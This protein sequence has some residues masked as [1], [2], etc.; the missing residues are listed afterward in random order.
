[1]VL[2]TYVFVYGVSAPPPHRGQ[3]RRRLHVEAGY[4]LFGGVGAALARAIQPPLRD[5][6]APAYP[7]AEFAEEGTWLGPL[8]HPDNDAMMMMIALVA[9]DDDDGGEGVTTPT[10]IAVC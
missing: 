4:D 10:V 5:A 9:G 2:H 6:H 3:S 1:M 7:P 8:L